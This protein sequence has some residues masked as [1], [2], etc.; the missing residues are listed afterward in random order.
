MNWSR[1]AVS[2]SS[3]LATA[4]GSVRDQNDA[5]VNNAYGFG[6]VIGPP[7]PDAK[8]DSLAFVCFPRAR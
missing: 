2:H 4:A 5:L 8:P 1:K 3:T 7:E 6:F